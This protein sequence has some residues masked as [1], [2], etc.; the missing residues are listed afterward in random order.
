MKTEDKLAVVFDPFVDVVREEALVVLVDLQ[1]EVNIDID[2][3]V[4]TIL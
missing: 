2:L 3:I 4:L 1:S